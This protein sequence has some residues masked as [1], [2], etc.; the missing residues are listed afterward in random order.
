M[1]GMSLRFY[2]SPLSGEFPALATATTRQQLVLVSVC[3][4]AAIVH[5]A[6]I[7]AIRLTVNNG[8]SPV[9]RLRQQTAEAV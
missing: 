1:D 9:L 3:R 7:H 5:I 2:L 4:P 8:S 6:D